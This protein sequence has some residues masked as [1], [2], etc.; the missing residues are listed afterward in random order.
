MKPSVG[1]SV[2]YFPEGEEFD[3]DLP[4]S[5]TITK[6][7]RMYGVVAEEE[8]SYEVNLR[9]LRADAT[10]SFGALEAPFSSTPK[11]GHWTWPPRV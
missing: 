8:D 9:V 7:S 10:G 1:R 6:V 3:S 4:L 5:A 11:P 2:H